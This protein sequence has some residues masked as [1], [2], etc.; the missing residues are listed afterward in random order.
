[1]QQEIELLR[2]ENSELR[3]RIDSLTKALEELT[4][5]LRVRNALQEESYSSDGYVVSNISLNKKRKISRGTRRPTNKT[6]EELPLS[7][8]YEMLI[9]LPENTNEKEVPAQQI[10]GKK[11]QSTVILY[12]RK[13]KIC[14]HRTNCAQQTRPNR[15]RPPDSPKTKRKMDR[16]K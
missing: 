14:V 11:H 4:V 16:S 12:P 13:E 15:K 6:A 3:K 9:D 2:R 5:Q 10:P 1:M 7:N 8:R